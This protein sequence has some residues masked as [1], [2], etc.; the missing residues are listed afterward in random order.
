[1]EQFYDSAMLDIESMGTGPNAAVVQIG[2]LA[3]N[4]QTGRVA[5][6]EFLVDI[7]LVSSVLEGGEVDQDTV[8]WW[9]EIGWRRPV[10]TKYLVGALAA[11]SDWFRNFPTVERVWAQGPSFDIAVLEGFYRRT[12][13]PAPWRYNAARDTRTVYDLARERGWEKPEG[14][15]PV[16]NG[17]GDSRRQII[18]L[19][20][21]LNVIRK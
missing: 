3:F 14:T 6:G 4:S 10:G 20:S 8:N 11:L 2:A 21:A 7:D 5:S 12:K 17:L 19:M 1:M 16:H 18:C 15:E 9:L 13:M